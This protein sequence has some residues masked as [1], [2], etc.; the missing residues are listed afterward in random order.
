MAILRLRL[1]QLKG[2]AFSLFNVFQVSHMTHL[3][4]CK[5]TYYFFKSKTTFASVR[6]MDDSTW[7]PVGSDEPLN[8]KKNII[9]NL[10]FLFEPLKYNFEH[11]DPIFF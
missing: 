8:W 4:I 3:I 5:P 7:S 1:E 11:I 9:Y 6:G 10:Y 2:L